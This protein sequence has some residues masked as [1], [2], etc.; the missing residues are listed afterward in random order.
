MT[1]GP[2]HF[3]PDNDSLSDATEWLNDPCP[4]GK[5]CP[6]CS[7]LDKEY[8]NRT[9]TRAMGTLLVAVVWYFERN[10]ES[11]VEVPPLAARLRDRGTGGGDFAKLRY[12]AWDLIE[13]MPGMRE[14]GSY[15]NGWWRPTPRAIPFVKGR[16]D[17]TVVKYCHIWRG[18]F[19]GAHGPQVTIQ[20]VM[21]QDFNY[22]ELMGPPL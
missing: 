3:D 19:H 8:V 12:P 7:K 20:D 10:G 1:H 9:I 14:D 2:F 13:P 4:E 6:A 5:I 11:W 21:G 17:A 16:P 22:G 15:R 18:E